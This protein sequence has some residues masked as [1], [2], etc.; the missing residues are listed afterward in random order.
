LHQISR[1]PQSGFQAL[2]EIDGRAVS[3]LFQYEKV[4]LLHHASDIVCVEQTAVLY[5]LSDI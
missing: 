3:A 2:P 1:H 5:P 4:S